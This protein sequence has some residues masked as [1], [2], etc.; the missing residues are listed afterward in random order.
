MLANAANKAADP[1]ERSRLKGEILACG[2]LM[3]LLQQDPAAWLKGDVAADVDVAEIENLIAARKDA[4]A[5][6][7]WA[8]SDRI[9]DALAARGILLEDKAGQTTWRVA[10]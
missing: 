2:T 6:K 7:D 4:R 3:G 8:E 5:R 10:S 1:A 9:R